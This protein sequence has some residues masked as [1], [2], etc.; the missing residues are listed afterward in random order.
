MAAH[1]LPLQGYQSASR[2][3]LLWLVPG[4]RERQEPDLGQA[5]PL[6]RVQML[7]LCTLK[8]Q[9]SLHEQNQAEPLQWPEH[10]RQ[11][12]QGWLLGLLLCQWEQIE[13]EAGLLAAMLAAQPQARSAVAGPEGDPPCW[14]AKREPGCQ[15]LRLLRLA[16]DLLQPSQG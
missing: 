13:A 15:R 11:R 9:P 3:V 2:H 16:A 6:L 7:L 5:K 8:L 10:A 4:R 12:R 1:Q 14:L